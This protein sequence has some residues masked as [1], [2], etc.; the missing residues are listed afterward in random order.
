MADDFAN[1]SNNFPPVD[2]S[3]LDI[4]QPGAD[5]VSEVQC[6]PTEVEVIDLLQASKKTS[7][8]PQDFPTTFVKEYLPFLAKPAMIIFSSSISPGPILQ[9][10]RP[11]MSL[12][13][14]K[15]F[16]LCPTEIFETSLLLNF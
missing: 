3:L 5:F 8:V 9:D 6:I 14:R 16:L 1:I 7:S 13:I 10:G 15:L 4:V 11:S 12:L 2:S